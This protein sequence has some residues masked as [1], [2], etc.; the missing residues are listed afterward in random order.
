MKDIDNIKP[1]FWLNLH[2]FDT[3][4]CEAIKLW[5]TVLFLKN[6]G[7]WKIILGFW[8]EFSFYGA[9]QKIRGIWL[10]W[11]S[12]KST[13]DNNV[14]AYGGRR[15]MAES[16]IIHKIRKDKLDQV[17]TRKSSFRK[18]E[19][20]KIQYGVWANL[21]NLKTRSGIFTRLTLKMDKHYAYN[22]KPG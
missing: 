21:F 1:N 12:R 11:Q 20:Q 8:A 18:E 10:P 5:K 14:T 15:F 19:G 7:L 9:A 3:N 6:S 13:K 22:E 17:S 2:S 4:I 16:M